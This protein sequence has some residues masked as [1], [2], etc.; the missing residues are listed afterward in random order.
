MDVSRRCACIFALGIVVV[1]A[2]CGGGGG[3]VVT[4]PSTSPPPP[5]SI[6][7]GEDVNLF[8]SNI[9]FSN[10]QIMYSLVA[11]SGVKWLRVGDGGWAADE[12]AHGQYKFSTLNQVIDGAR[13]A[14]LG[15]LLEI[16]DSTPSWD[17]PPGANTQN[18]SVAYAPADCTGALNG[19]TDCAAF[20]EYVRALVQ[21]VMPLGVHYLVVWNEPQNMPKNWIG[22]NGQSVTQLA[23]DYAQML[24]Q[25]YTNAHAVDPT[26]EILNG[27]TEILPSTLLSI[28]EKYEPGS[29]LQNAIA[30][31]QELY[32]NSL[33]CRS[34]DVLDVHVGD[35][36]PTFSKEIV[37]DSE[38]AIQQCNGGASLPVWVTESGYSNI[39]AVQSQPE[40][41]AELGTA[42]LSGDTSQQQYLDDTWGALEADSD[43]IG[44][45][46]T[47]V[48]D[49]PYGG[50]P[51]QD[52]AGLGIT[53][54]SFNKKPV[55][56]T[57]QQITK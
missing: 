33:F 23:D 47:F 19:E 37:D 21:D 41:E 51:T 57:M 11:G 24:H 38:Q 14:G 54:A 29:T 8:Q 44:I 39:Q 9:G 26:I 6:A 4:T 42:Y 16:G 34:I 56:S 30:F 13:A 31:T 35:H 43:V 12:T 28:L 2:A 18:N 1:L 45:D 20:G 55:Y 22:S 53:D 32:V 7:F 10:A 50:N 46:W 49:P 52:G 5:R 36:G 27:G 48:A 15:V 40:I 25:A 3:G 17:L